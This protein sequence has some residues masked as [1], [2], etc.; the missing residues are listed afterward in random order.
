MTS[1]TFP[2][3]KC[4]CCGFDAG[5]NNGWFGSDTRCLDCRNDADRTANGWNPE[6][7]VD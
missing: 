2:N 1:T 5:D 7:S 4:T 3:T 6:N